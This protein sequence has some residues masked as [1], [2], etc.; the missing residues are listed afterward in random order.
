[1]NQPADTG[2]EAEK[3]FGEFRVAAW[4]A[5]AMEIAAAVEPAVPA[6]LD[7]V[8]LNWDYQKKVSS[9]FKFYYLIFI[10]G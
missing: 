6:E 3:Y 10:K 7:W 2:A 5:S 9:F 4:P 1:M 8:R